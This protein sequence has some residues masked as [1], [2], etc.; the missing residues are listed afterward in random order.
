L[1][2]LLDWLK[3]KYNPAGIALLGFSGGAAIAIYN[4]A[5]DRRVSA[6][7]SASA[8]AFFDVLTESKNAGAWLENFKKIGLI[9]DQ[10]FPE[11]VPD[12]LHEFDL[13]R[14]LKWVH[15]ISPRPVLF[16]HGDKD[17]V[18]PVSHARM[19]YKK[20]RAPKELWVIKGAPHKLRMDERA[21]EK[22]RAWLKQWKES[23]E[24]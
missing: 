24:K 16:L 20:A 3:K 13:V 23:M 6:L 2:A 12:W 1:K 8:P 18:V 21:V 7:V 4:A 14:P 19:L 10:N 22:A 5:H 17:E 11:S 9:R 15:K